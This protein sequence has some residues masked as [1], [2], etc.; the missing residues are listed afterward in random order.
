[1][2]SECAVIWTGMEERR[3]RCDGVRGRRV[4]EVL[5]WVCEGGGSLDGMGV[6]SC[7]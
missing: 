2:Y 5:R 7:G 1:M 4:V 3:G 6:M